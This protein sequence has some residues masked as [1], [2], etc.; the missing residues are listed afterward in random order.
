[1][2]LCFMLAPLQANHLGSLYTS[3]WHLLEDI[4]ITQPQEELNSWTNNCIRIASTTAAIYASHTL[5]TKAL[6]AMGKSQVDQRT[7]MYSSG[8]TVASSLIGAATHQGI[9]KEMEHKLE[10][11]ALKNFIVQWPSYRTYAPKEIKTVLDELYEQHNKNALSKTHL[12]Q[13][14]RLLKL[15]IYNKFPEKYKNK[16]AESFFNIRKFEADARIEAGNFLRGAAELWRA[17]AG[18]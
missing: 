9:K 18:R 10:I 8:K 6:S 4:V 5:F 11:A 16:D 3:D 12:K 2:A 7:F 13:T 17:L 15:A 1:M 14:I